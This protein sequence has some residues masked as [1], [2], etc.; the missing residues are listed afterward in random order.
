MTGRVF[1]F[2]KQLA[3]SQTADVDKL[4]TRALREKFGDELLNIHRSHEH[5]DRLGSDYALEF[6]GGKYEHLD[7]KIRSKDYAPNNVALEY[8]TGKK[9]GWVIDTSKITDWLL[10]VWMDT[11]K[12]SLHHARMLR[13]IARKYEQEWQ[14]TAHQSTQTSN[15]GYSSPAMYLSDRDIWAAEYRHFSCN[16]APKARP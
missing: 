9:D 11:G 4:V 12:S 8:R 5:N 16:P 7:V 14:Q 10:F 2:D 3:A 6:I 1:N 15:G 13:V